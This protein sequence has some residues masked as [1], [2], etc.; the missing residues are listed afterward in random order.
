MLARH[1]DV[2]A[3]IVNPGEQSWAGGQ[4]FAAATLARVAPKFA[5]ALIPG[6]DQLLPWSD[7]LCMARLVL[8]CL[9]LVGV[10]PR[11]TAG[12]LATLS[13]A[14]FAAD[15]FHYVHH[16]LILYLCL[17]CLVFDDGAAH[18]KDLK[19]KSHRVPF[20]IL[21]LR[22]LGAVVYLAAGF[23]KCSTVWLSGRTM[24]ALHA[25]GFV[26]GELFDISREFMGYQGLAWGACL[27]ELAVPLL[28]ARQKT[29]LFGGAMAV[30]LHLWIHCTMV[31]STFG[32]T[33]VVLL[34]AY[35][36]QPADHPENIIEAQ[37]ERWRQAKAL[38]LAF[39]VPVSAFLLHTGIGSFSMFTRLVHYELSLQVDGRP[40]PRG[41]V[42]Q[43]L[44]RDGAR[45]VAL[46]NGRGVGETNVEILTRSLPRLNQFL[47]DLS[48][49]GRV[50]RLQLTTWRIEGGSASM[51]TRERRCR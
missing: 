24:R 39:M 42:I 36:P 25:E 3:N 16:L 10:L 19:S 47:C 13:L 48:P 45:V 37:A 31:V 32:A 11:V 40:V 6:L 30:S 35:L 49:N 17:L 41:Q 43:H 7:V 4:E 15:G 18:K 28:L 50:A 5:R 51:T 26:G 29:R 14:I 21:L 8:T 22:A 46:A 27:S 33:M 12:L 38:G 44:G 34:F 23:A 9:L 20:V 1:D 2:F